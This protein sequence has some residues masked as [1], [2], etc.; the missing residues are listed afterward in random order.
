MEELQQQ[1]NGQG[2]TESDYE[3]LMCKFLVKLETSFHNVII[4]IQ[5]PFSPLL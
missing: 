2:M 1:T 5:P 4:S 3:L